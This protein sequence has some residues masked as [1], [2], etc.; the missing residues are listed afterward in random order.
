MAQDIDWNLLAALDVLL[1]EGSVTAAADR[2]HLS[3]PATSRTL[4]RIRRAFGDPILVRAGRGLVPT[5]RALAIQERLHQLIEEAHALMG[6]GR[7]LELGS[8]ERTFTIRANDAIVSLLTAG[9]VRSIKAVAPA[10]TL[11]FAP[12]GAEDLAPLR[13]GLIDLD[14]GV[15]GDLGPEVRTQPL[16]QEH[17][18]GLAAAGHSLTVGPVTLD[19][20]AAADHIAV[21]RRGRPRGALD[22]ILT[23]RG[24]TR[25]VVAVVPTF[26]S[27][28]HIIAGSDL[29]GLIP[30]RYARQVAASTG[31]RCYDIP[32]TLP[33]LTMA[34]AWHVR[35]DL[36]PAHHW[37]RTQI[38]AALS[39]EY[40]EDLAN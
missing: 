21:S 6:A 12:E 26:T 35:H 33:T 16:Y 30:A 36:D 24:L 5:P 25:N 11:R 20:L 27:A 2:L 9:L 34:L 29:T 28:A 39:V 7:G 4:G 32:V 37:L 14:L 8:L 23:A 19:R 40:A 38:A 31:A 1:A 15:I 10:V 18:V 17:L 22:D 13:D 3:V